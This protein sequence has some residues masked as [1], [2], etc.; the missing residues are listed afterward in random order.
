MRV[1]LQDNGADGVVIVPPPY[2]APPQHAIY[3]HL[4]AVCQSIDIAVGFYNN[5][6]RVVVN[7]DP[8]TIVRIFN[9]CPNLVADKEAVPDVGQ[10]ASVLD[11]TGGRIRLLTCDSPAYAMIIPTLG[12]GGHGTANV[13]GNVA[14]REVAEMSKPWK[15]WEDVV[16]CRQLYFELLPLMEAVYSAPN[17]SPPRPWSGS[18]ACPPATAGRLCR[19]SPRSCGGPWRRLSSGSTSN[20]STA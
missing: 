2:I 4:K 9:E 11:G 20:E 10:L 13:T 12:M 19:T 3:E 6:A 17:P 1:T 15:S 14:P 16:R 8:E 7:I 5:P 18:W